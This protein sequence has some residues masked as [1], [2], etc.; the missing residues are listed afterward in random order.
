[1]WWLLWLNPIYVMVTLVASGFVCF[2]PDA[3]IVGTIHMIVPGK[4][5]CCYGECCCVVM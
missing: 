3:F 2:V 1:M 4:V 5:S